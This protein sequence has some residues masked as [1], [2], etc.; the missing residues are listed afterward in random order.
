[1]AAVHFLDLDLKESAKASLM[2]WHGASNEST[3]SASS[4]RSK[5][6][7]WRKADALGL[8]N[9]IEAKLPIRLRARLD[10]AAAIA[11]P[12]IWILQI[13]HLLPRSAVWQRLLTTIPFQN[14]PWRLSSWCCA[15]R[16]GAIH[17]GIV[18]LIVRKWTPIITIHCAI[19]I[20]ARFAVATIRKQLQSK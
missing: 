19:R 17:V 6:V 12:G 8:P 4:K 11:R 15:Q 13:W 5:G 9:P 2:Q 3:K 18:F 16:H 14:K 20:V 1:V 10:Y 7:V